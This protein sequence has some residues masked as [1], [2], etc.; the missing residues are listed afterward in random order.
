MANKIVVPEDEAQRI[1]NNYLNGLSLIEAGKLEGF[2]YSLTRRIFDEYNFQLKKSHPKRTKVEINGKVEN[3]IKDYENGMSLT[4]CAKKYKTNDTSLKKILKEHNIYI[5]TA[6][7]ARKQIDNRKYK[8]NDKKA[9]EINHNIAWLLGFIA[10]DGYIVKSQ[11][12]K[13][14]HRISIALSIKDIEVLK[15][16]KDYIE[17]TGPIYEYNNNGYP[18]ASLTFSSKP[19]HEMLMKYGIINNKTFIL[20]FPKNLPEEYYLDF[21]H[22]YFDGDGSVYKPNDGHTIRTNLIGA[23][24][25]FIEDVMN[26]LVNNAEIKC[27]TIHQRWDKRST[28]PLYYFTFNKANSEKLYKYFYNEKILFLDRKK[29]LFEEYLHMNKTPTS[30]NTPQG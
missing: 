12:D 13:C 25:D 27:T 21:I 11:N 24:K 14:L 30:L 5:R 28:A 3:F 18:A 23:S 10:A 8:I 6:Q 15:R 4:K 9:T 26:I 2:G 7:E 17:F 19:F 22:G 20:K 1:Y 16:I 29:E